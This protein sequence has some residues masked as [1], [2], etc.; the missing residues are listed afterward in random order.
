MDIQITQHAFDR[1][2]ERSSW[3]ESVLER[4]AQRAYT[5]GF[6]PKNMK[7]RLKR[8]VDSKT[9]KHHSTVYLHG[10]VLYFFKQNLLV[11]LYQIPNDLKGHLKKL[12][13]T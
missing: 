7:A 9:I 4:M 3:S 1:A 10:E 11:T 12:K 8:F 2:K 5:D 13:K 6:E